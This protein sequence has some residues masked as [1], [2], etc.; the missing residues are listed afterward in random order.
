MDY[1]N[2]AVLDGLYQAFHRQVPWH[3]RPA[4]F[5]ALRSWGLIELVRQQLPVGA[6]YPPFDIAAVTDRGK[7][8][9]ERL[10]G[11]RRMP[12]WV[13]LRHANYTGER[14]DAAGRDG[15]NVTDRVVFKDSGTH[16]LPH[17][18]PGDD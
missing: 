4:I 13:L 9:I 15:F 14:E 10:E 17:D 6:R 12:D 11:Q 8:A 16:R 18:E 3:K 2:E 1:S 5:S 7:A